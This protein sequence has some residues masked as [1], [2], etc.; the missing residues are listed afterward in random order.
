MQTH[1][2]QEQLKK[3]LASRVFRNSARMSRFL[4]YTVKQALRGQSESLKETLVGSKVFDRAPDYDP[5]ID[6][7]V[8][9]E[10]RRLRQKLSEYYATA[11][12]EDTVIIEYP[13][14]TYWPRFSERKAGG[15]KQAD[16]PGKMESILVLPF[17]NL[18][19]NTTNDYFS[20][21]LTQ[22]LI[23]A[24][25]Q[26]KGLRVVGWSSAARLR[27]KSPQSSEV[28]GQVQT[29]AILEGTVS[30]EG[31]LLRIHA[32]L[33][34]AATGVYLWTQSYQREMEGLFTLQ[35]EIARSIAAVLRVRLTEGGSSQRKHS[36]EAHDFYLKGRFEWFRRTP[37]S[38]RQSIALFQRAIGEDGRCAPAYAGLADAHSLLADYSI[39][40]STESMPLARQAALRA[41]ELDPNLGEA[42]VSLAIVVGLYDWDWARA[43][44]HYKKAI[45]LNPGYVTA[46]HWYGLDH[47]A[48]LGRFEEAYQHLTIAADLDPLEPILV[49]AL[50]FLAMLR[51]DFDD[52][53]RRYER[54]T[55]DFPQFPR[56]WTGL[57]RA[58]FCLGH[59]GKAIQMLEKG[60]QISGDLPSVMGALAQTYGCSGNLVKARRMLARLH[61]I[62]RGQH[63]AASCLALA[64]LGLGQQEEALEWLERGVSRRDMP[65]TQIGVHAAYD[66]LRGDPRFEELVRRVGLK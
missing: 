4:T 5:R 7:I 36:V 52:A 33:V 41:L 9:V 18:D 37:D 51:R 62:A 34:Q 55:K 17:I 38:I 54:M 20:D 44:S 65:M 47:L 21:G 49:E 11:G 64:H 2:I 15:A 30:R 12:S 31:N 24:L 26:V 63:V 60:R 10:A 13:K 46:H 1:Q 27:G 39:E 42:H 16:G 50:A 14:G 48:L 3:L 32:Q 25:T 43:E 66:A 56:S 59:Y 19:A 35:E 53:A 58:N 8:R 22:E 57:G 6:P 45:A 29:D 61:E 40:S 23:H 28:I